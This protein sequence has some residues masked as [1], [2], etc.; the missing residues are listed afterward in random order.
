MVDQVD[1]DFSNV[2]LDRT[3]VNDYANNMYDDN[4]ERRSWI[5]CGNHLPRSEIVFFVQTVLVFMLVG[6]SITCL[7]LAK[8]CEETTVWVAVLSSSVGYMLPSPKL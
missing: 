4:L 6:V 2:I 5:L 8:T 3:V 1:L 7:A